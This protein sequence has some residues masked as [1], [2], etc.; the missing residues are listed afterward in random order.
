[1]WRLRYSMAFCLTSKC[2]SHTAQATECKGRDWE[3]EELP[4]VGEDQVQEH[5]RKLKM[6]KSMG[7]EMHPWVLR[8][9]ADE[10]AKWLP[11]NLRSHG[12]LLHHSGQLF[13]ASG[14]EYCSEVAP[15]HKTRNHVPRSCLIHC[16]DTSQSTHVNLPKALL[17]DRW[18]PCRT[19][20]LIPGGIF[21]WTWW[22]WLEWPVQ[23]K[24]SSLVHLNY[25][26]V[27]QISSERGKGLPAT[28]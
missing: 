10:V 23:S 3:K 28:F 8:E 25:V 18:H 13:L 12:S 24:L 15:C 16:S 5:L 14:L 2:S 11:S 6:H 9:L 19:P 27:P 4:A 1:M 7:H 17:L 22:T 21:C 26:F 20:A